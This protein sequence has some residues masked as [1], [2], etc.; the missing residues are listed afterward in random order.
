MRIYTESGGFLEICTEYDKDLKP[1]VKILASSGDGRTEMC[2]TAGLKPLRLL[3]CE[4]GRAI[5]TLDVKEEDNH[6]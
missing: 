1:E 4:M 6:N 5:K 3:M 2:F